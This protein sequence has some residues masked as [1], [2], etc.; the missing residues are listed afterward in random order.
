MELRGVGW[1]ALIQQKI[2]KESQMKFITQILE[3]EL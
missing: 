1:W 3:E 2:T